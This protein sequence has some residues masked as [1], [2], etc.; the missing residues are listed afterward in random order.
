MDAIDKYSNILTNGTFTKNIGILGSPSEGKI[1]C[2]MYVIL[3]IISKGLK[4]NE[5]SMMCKQDMQLGGIYAHQTWPIPVD[6][7]ITSRICAE[8]G[9]LKL[10]NKPKK[11]DLILSLDL[12]FFDEMG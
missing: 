3:Y 6:E 7:N 5:I 2:G 11:M 4:C 10:V 8:L 12:L 1:W 9:L